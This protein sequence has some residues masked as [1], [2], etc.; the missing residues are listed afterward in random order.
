[1]ANDVFVS[2]IVHLL[3][4]VGL[5]ALPHPVLLRP[6]RLAGLL[7][8]LTAGV[9]SVLVA[10]QGLPLF[11]PGVLHVHP[12]AIAAAA[13]LFGPLAGA[14]AATIALTSQWLVVN[15]DWGAALGLTACS[16]G[17]GLTGWLAYRRGRLNAWVV[18]MALA[19]VLPPA[20]QPWTDPNGVAVDS[21]REWWLRGIAW[22]YSIGVA[23]LCGFGVML[24]ER[25]IWLNAMREREDNLLLALKAA[26]GGRWEWDVRTRM[27][28]YRGQF[29]RNFGLPDSP[30]EGSLQ[31]SLRVSEE[32]ARQRWRD[33]WHPDD[34]QR[35]E[36]SL[37]VTMDGLQDNVQDQFRMRDDQGRWRWLISRGHAV[38]RDASGRVLRLAGIDLDITEHHETQEALRVSQAK[39][40]TVY[41]TLPD[42]AGIT[43]LADGCYLDVN[44]AF[45]RMLGKPRDQILGRT[46]AELGV[47]AHEDQRARLVQALQ[48]HG[49]VRGLPMTAHR[50]GEKLPGLMSAR[51]V[52]IEGEECLIFV[53]HDLTQEQRVRDELLTA[54]R[55]L[56]E[57]G[58]MARLGV[59]E[60]T[61][62]VGITYWSDV[63]FDIHGLPASAPLPRCYVDHFVAPAWR[64]AVRSEMRRSLQDRITWSME[65]EIHR[66]DGQLLWVRVRGEPVVQDGQVVRVRGILQD[67]DESRRAAQRLRSSEE[68]LARIFELLPLYLL[69][70]EVQDMVSESCPQPDSPLG[71]VS[72]PWESMRR[73]QLTV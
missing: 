26:G 65:I 54:N 66:A 13:F 1:M 69:N 46:S 9:A 7:L 19:L 5:A 39:Y 11:S 53:F 31:P 68:R 8:G 33:R 44:P 24:R 47:W 45:E 18:V 3:L 52:Q 50:D 23:V 6:S 59:W 62:G 70:L 34:L 42:A 28:S 15:A 55:L 16:L 32:A 29:Y 64:D 58:W 43:R 20:I 27:F 14:V 51:T 41:Q 67:I 71:A 2:G 56:R 25:A 60:E 12:P 40:T 37:H 36:N 30:D 73:G 48:N 49:E 72:I 35:L 61:P 38:E 57:A 21:L 10:L 17:M 4:L 63:C 22:R